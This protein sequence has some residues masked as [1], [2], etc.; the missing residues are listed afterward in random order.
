MSLFCHVVLSR[1][2]LAGERAGCFTFIVILL[3]C[4]CMPVLFLFLEVTWVCLRSAIAVLPGHTLLL[5][6]P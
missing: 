1:N 4:G 6:G 5:L 3:W 2:H